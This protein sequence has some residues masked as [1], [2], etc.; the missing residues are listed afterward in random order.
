MTSDDSTADA[1][2]DLVKIP[3]KRIELAVNALRQQAQTLEAERSDED[4]AHDQRRIADALADSLDHPPHTTIADCLSEGG[5][6][7][8]ADKL[9]F[10]E[11]GEIAFPGKCDGCRR[12][13]YNVFENVG[14]W[15]PGTGSWVLKPG[16]DQQEHLHPRHQEWEFILE[17]NSAQEEGDDG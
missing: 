17:Q 12:E 6:I 9:E 8:Y 7:S 5:S 11:T 16:K 15:D 1:G 2:T 13:F 14:I 10:W 4:A 3:R